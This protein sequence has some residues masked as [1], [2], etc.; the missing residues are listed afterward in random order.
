[1]KE[2]TLLERLMMILRVILSII[3]W[4]SKILFK[5]GRDMLP[6]AGKGSA[7]GMTPN[8]TDGGSHSAS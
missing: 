5:T 4:V 2:Y 8:R 6:G 7:E 1:M 3:G